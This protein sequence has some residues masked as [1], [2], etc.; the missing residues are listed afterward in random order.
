MPQYRP[1]LRNEAWLVAGPAAQLLAV[2]NG[3]GEEARAVGGA[4]RN[5]L[6]QVP[7]EDVD[8]ATTALPDEILRRALA[9]GFKAVPTGIDHGTVTVIVR[10]QPFEV[11]TLRE[12]VETFGRRARVAFGR[13]WKRD[14]E[15]RDF[16][17]N[18]LSAS[19]D[20]AIHDYVGGLADLALRRVRFIG[21]AAT[22]IAEDYL[23]I[24]RFFR[25]HAAYGK[26]AF[27]GDAL[28]AVIG[29]RAGLASLSGERVQGE[30]KK[31]LVAPG[32]VPSVEAMGNAGLLLILLGGV[33]YHASLREMISIERTLGLAA[34]PVRRLAALAVAIP[35]D[36][37]RLVQRL[38]L[39]NA[40]A[41]R[42]DSMAYRW[43]R[44]PSL[45]EAGARVRLYKLGVERYRDR[46]LMAFARADDRARAERM[47]DLVSLP[48][49][50]P[51]PVFPLKAGDFIARGLREGPSL[52]AALRSAENAWIDAGF[53]T[54]AAA[55]SAIAETAAKKA[56]QP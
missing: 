46:M 2:L 34:D 5:A 42:L 29:G 1:D 16:T 49:R 14:A 47:A 37:E 9:S 40:D 13:D 6:L 22:R 39:S 28:H 24:L 52:G 7:V 33:T 32:A 26:G 48:E 43:R 44:W 10:G 54:D 41:R 11:T 12:D 53:P 55:L 17:I 38:R 23:R 56:S 19:P 3:Q 35:E 27:D 21:D 20:G 36:A 25:I 51:V 15:R 4:V 18:A 45:D 50:W 8:I 30:L 31:L